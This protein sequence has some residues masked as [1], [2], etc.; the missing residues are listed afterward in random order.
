MTR[1]RLMLLGSLALVA[2][3]DERPSET[4][5]TLDSGLSLSAGSDDGIDPTNDGGDDDDVLDVGQGEGPDDDDGG[6]GGECPCENVLDGIYVLHSTDPPAVYFYDPPDNT[7]TPIGQL[8]CQAE[9]GATANSMAID[10]QGNA[11]INYYSLSG[12]EPTG[13][14]YRAPLTGLDQCEDLGYAATST[15][16]LLGMGYAVSAQGSSCDTLFVYNSD[17]YIDYPVFQPGG[18]Q[19]ARFDTEDIETTILGPTDYPVGELSGTGDGRLFAFATVA[20]NQSVLAQLDKS[21]GTELESIPLDGLDI[22]NAF[23][24]AFWG[25]DV[26]FF[27]ETSP[28]ATTSKVTRLDYDGNDGGGLSIV[29]PDAGIHIAGAGVSTCASFTPPG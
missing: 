14:M 9:S 6:E 25:G 16:Y 29:N 26:Y 5:M 7:F 3:A 2:C 15:W 17:Q 24:F 10:R 18:S 28:G 12:L 22:T 4:G 21:D 20:E 8:G 11:W 1:V 27:T 19:L 23:A 13:R